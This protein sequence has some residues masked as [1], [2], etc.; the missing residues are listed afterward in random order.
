MHELR[1]TEETL[2]CPRLVAN[3]HTTSRL[4][5][6]TG[7]AGAVAE[8]RARSSQQSCPLR[9][10]RTCSRVAESFRRSPGTLDRPPGAHRRVPGPDRE[11]WARL[12][13]ERSA[14]E[15]CWQ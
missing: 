2:R 11:M 3:P 1:A 15:F 13:I 12:E 5:G 9:Y 14:S 4:I 6:W 10:T 8:R 7:P